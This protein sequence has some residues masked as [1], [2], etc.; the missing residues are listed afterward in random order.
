MAKPSL[1]NLKDIHLPHPLGWWPLATGWY[2]LGLIVA[3]GFFS[4]LFFII[5]HFIRGRSKRQALRVLKSYQEDDAKQH[6][7][8]QSSARISELL[9]RVALVYYPRARVASLQG[10]AW[11]DF[12]NQSAQH[13]D[14]NTVSFL[15]TECPYQPPGEHDVSPLFHLAKGW[16]KQ[17]RHRCSS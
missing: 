15:L 11:I 14:F 12:L 10:Q 2:I 1:E 6:N 5:R 8:Q 4:L 17:R 3:V 7:S 16:I 9:K 13:I